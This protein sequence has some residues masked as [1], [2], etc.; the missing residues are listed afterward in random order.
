MKKVK[1]LRFE[2]GSYKEMLNRLLGM[3]ITQCILKGEAAVTLLPAA[4]VLPP[5]HLSK[6]AQSS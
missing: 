6:S 4:T 5:P 3:K 2:T 1:I